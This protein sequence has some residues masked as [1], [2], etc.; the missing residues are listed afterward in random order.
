MLLI[1]RANTLETV[2]FSRLFSYRRRFHFGF[3]SEL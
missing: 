3:L 2:G 1:Y